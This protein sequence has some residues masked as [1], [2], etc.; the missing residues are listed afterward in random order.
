[1]WLLACGL[2]Q[3]MPSKI[4]AELMSWQVEPGFAKSLQ[5]SFIID[6]LH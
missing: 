3:N 4:F 6:I 5:D 2:T 1:M